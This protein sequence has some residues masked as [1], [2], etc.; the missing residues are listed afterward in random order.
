LNRKTTYIL[1]TLVAITV[2]FAIW[3]QAY[4]H[5]HK[6]P[7]NDR[8]FLS[9]YTSDTTRY[10]LND[11]Y[12][13]P[14][15]YRNRNPF[16]LEDSSFIKRNIVY[17]PLTK[18]YYIEEKIGNNYYRT[19]MSF[20]MKEFLD[21]QGKMDE[22]DYFRKR[23]SLLSSMNRRLYKP[24]FKFFNNWVNRI[25]GNGKIDIRPTGYVDL[26]AGYTGQNIK[27]PT[28]P[29][30]ARKNGGFDFNMNSQLQVDANIG[31]KLKLPINYN[32]QSVFNF[33][34]QL[35]LDYHGEDDEILKEFQAGNVSFNSKG[36]LIP[37]AQ[38]LFGLK[39]QLQFGKLFITSV[40]ANQ[41][42]QRQ[43]LGLQGSSA[44]QNFALKADEYE[45]NRHFLLAQ[46]FRNKYNDA[47]KEL[48]IVRSAVQVQKMEVWVTNRTAYTDTRDIVALMDL[49]EGSPFGPWGGS[50][51]N[52][53]P[54]NNA[55]SLYQALLAN[56][57]ARNSTQAQSALTGMGLQPVQ[58][59]EKTYA[60]KLQPTEYYYNPQIGFLSLNQQ[61]Q[62]DEVLGV[63]YQYTYNGKVYQVGEFSQDVPPDSTANNQ[64][65]L[66][67]KLLKAT[68]QRPQLPIWDLMMKNV[69]SVG[70]GQLDRKDFQLDILYEEPSLGQKRYLPPDPV[71]PQY[72]GQ[73]I[74]SLVNLDRLN[75]QNDPVP[76]GYFDYVE[77]FT[78]ISSQSRI[79]FP[80]L[81]PFGHDLDYVYA[82]Q[83][84]RDK[85]LYYP[86]YDTIKAIAQTYANLDRFQLAGRSTSSGSGDYQ[87]GFNIPRGSVTVT[88]GGQVLQENVD[89]EINYDLG[90]LK[91]INPAIISTGLPVQVQYENNATYGLQQKN[92]I[93]I[94]A[95]YLVNRHL[96]LGATMVRLGERPFFTKTSYGEDPVKNTMYGADFDYRN[97]IPRLSKWLDKLPFYSTKA[98]SSITA[99]GEVAVLDPG[100]PKQIGKG[101]QGVSYIDDFEGTRSDID[102]RFP[103]IGWTLASVPYNAVD[104]SNN[105]LFPEAALNNNL[106]SGYNRAKLAWY[107]IEPVLQEKNNTSNPIRRNLAELSK[108]ESR[109]VLQS[110]IFPQRSTELGLGVLTTFDLAYYPREKGP[111]NFEFHNGRV[112]ANG[113]L[114][115]PKQ[116]WGGIMRNIDQ[117]D[118]E[119]SNIE[120]IEFWLQ[121]PFIRKPF[122]NGGQL[123]FNLGNISEDILKD[124]KRQYENGLAT[125]KNPQLMDT[126][127][128]WGQVPKNPLQVT[129]AFS[130]DPEDR[131]LQDVGYD[132]LTDTAEIRKFS[133]YL[134]DLSALYGP[135]SAIYQKALKDPSADDFK[136]Y[137]DD[138]YGEN[139]G[140]LARY[141]D[142]NNPHG[143]SP[144][145]NN[146]SQFTNAFTLYPDQEDLNRDNTM[147]ETEEYFQYRV[148]LKPGSLVPGQNFITD[149]REA[150]VKLAD[151]SSR[152]EHWYLF[153]IPIKAYQAKVG[154]IP[155]F[156][157]IRFI[158]MF[159]TGFD[160]TVV[161]RFGK[162]ELV[163]NQWRKFTYQIDTTGN[164][165]TLP[166]NDPVTTNILAVNLEENDQREPI[167]Y[168]IPPGIERQQ[169]LS[170]N[171]VQLLLNE[172]SLSLQVCSLLKNQAR[173]VFKTLNL[174]LRQ[175]GK[176]SMFIHLEDAKNPGN[177]IADGDVNAVI[178]L[179]NDF[180]SNYYEIKIPLKVTAW[181]ET[182]SARIW[183]PENNLDFDL[184]DLVALKVLRNKTGISPSLYFKQTLSNGRSYGI[185]GNP[186]LGEVRGMLM[187]IENEA[188]ENI[189]AEAWFNELRLSKLD[190]KG[191]YAAVGRV[192]INLA[193]LG[194]IS[195]AGSMHSAGFG[196]LEQRVNERSKEDQYQFDLAT[197]LDLGKL[198]PKRAG[199]QIPVYAGINRTSATPQY[200]PYDL[201]IKLKD[202]LKDETSK[203]KRDSIR[204]DAIDLTTTKTVT[205]N[206][207]RKIRT[208]KGKPMPWDVSNLDFNYS[209]IQTLH[210]SPLIEL[211][212]LR[213]TRG[214]ITYSYS[215]QV[216]PLEPFK[217]LIRS[218]SPWLALIRDFN[219]NYAP[220]VI[221]VKADAFRQFGA[222]RPRNVG[223]GPYK[224]PET[225][226]KFFNFDRYY[227]VNWALTNSIRIDYSA[228]NNA[229]VDEPFG[230]I[231][232][233]EKKDSIR[234]NFF[235]GG[236]T[237]HFGQDVTITYLLP[238]QKLPLLDWTAIHATYKA[239]YDWDAASLLATNLGNT[240]INGQ[241]RNVTGEFNFD[242]LYRKS[243]LL[244]LIN[245]DGPIEKSTEARKLKVKVKPNDST[246]TKMKWVRNPKWQPGPGKVTRFIGRFF[247][248]LKNVGIE[249]NEDAGTTLP[250]YLDST[251][252]FGHNFRSGNPDFGFIFGYQPDTNYINKLGARGLLTHDTLFN[253]LIQ[254]RYSQRLTIRAQLSPIRD[255][256]IDLRLEKTY[257]KNYSE[258]YKDT[259]AFDNVGL[260]R[261]NP[262]AM[263][264]F[265]ITYISYQT[266]FKKF[267]PNKLS[268]T[269][270]Q[271][272]ANR[273]L[274]SKRLSAL[275]PYPGNGT[276]DPND[277]NYYLGYGRYAQDVVIP[278]FIAAY[279]NKD[280]LSVKLIK[281]TNPNL[282]SNPF[283]GLIPKPNWTI[284]Y[285]GLSKLP[286][287]D[288]IFT[289]VTIRNG[290]RSNLSM[291]SFNTALLFEDPFHT[292]YPFF[293]DPLTNNYIPYFLV[294]N[295]TI[296]EAFEPLIGVD[297]TF[298][299]ALTAQFEYKKSRTLSLSLVD[300][301]LAENR[302]TEVS[303]GINWRKRG[304][305]I[306]RK[307]GKMKLDNEVTFKLEFSLRDD[308]T[309]NSKLDQ[310]GAF[311]T[312]G[313]KVVRIDPTIDYVINSRVKLQ[314][315]FDQTKVI[316][317]IYTT[318][319]VTNTK[320][321]VKV[322]I[323]LNQ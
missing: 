154:N 76:N 298:A 118:F 274:L 279:T 230:R 139:D 24:K 20:S 69:Y 194:N 115:N 11:R 199:I 49:G 125:P 178:R 68:S 246:S 301:Q 33:D 28:L 264:S 312:A 81:E 146:N 195:F 155:D 240:L 187:G 163:R 176:M 314:F 126:T 59:F 47:M 36:T 297:M 43:S 217:T 303:L 197:N 311:G 285:N 27:N 32:T 17:D 275:N 167:P 239:R 86:L 25:T 61:L 112:N 105:I 219:F 54:N 84:D 278:A 29:E 164:Y 280:P 116:A 65:V 51:V 215:P 271:F 267:D 244:R 226:N 196:T 133:Q 100:H 310:D 313:Q 3:P 179:G 249:Y 161:C 293:K 162:L 37:G 209:Y 315:Y 16:Y 284:T 216:K 182:D 80:V 140:I 253:S 40:L 188:Q 38:S 4:A 186:N 263:G 322:T 171:N 251:E 46:Y 31:D 5:D 15:N 94:R 210:H 185:I 21:M 12:G 2:L 128:V 77:G 232:T 113:N 286:G 189:C 236:R 135:N 273:A 108:P 72:K 103:L 104:Q 257:D 8:S 138:S 58:D 123:Y 191:G 122:S 136:N 44:T 92:F 289:N 151:G 159:M 207:V 288:K 22:E 255:L 99:Y 158:R 308:A 34:N 88:A 127:T 64:K 174:D 145:A 132:G 201:D 85:Y 260:T 114:L 141:K 292:G 93:G 317:K 206:S 323:S 13:D 74:L 149:V 102:L 296:S 89:Y 62:P 316:P 35:K 160:D 259:S 90:T 309:S 45:E 224:V 42:S 110:E 228:V 214:A 227:I 172:Q 295:I 198:L 56:P 281:N 258:L 78:V 242:Q 147:N 243:K 183:W 205:F 212:E 101:G 175:Y 14:Y 83:A 166:T 190:E 120:Y 265:N 106:A 262:Y 277:P 71:V 50:G 177:T 237:T 70:Y 156:K 7:K 134:T 18:E 6:D 282:R 302:S 233:K 173:G 153:R 96:T 91:I 48:P 231:D 221:S 23:A 283:S 66:F 193:D 222:T 53:L 142:Y 148:D 261:L 321:G 287:L 276:P 256:T 57:A 73:P 254:Q 181:G 192:D 250:G 165:T 241:T 211:D 268:E 247:T 152:T 300:Y 1:R 225:Y 306:I 129:N 208:G 290:Y 131:P 202:K 169:E 248:A 157:S 223:G 60:R 67:L 270:K 213:R 150:N 10:P 234:K 75:D 170:N 107:N 87:L 299:N 291:N 220:N 203:T 39:T 180:V 55:N 305:P 143:N 235:K 111:Y 124:G 26:L 52:A 218:K 245:T 117:T 266:L 41:R 320:A 119:T 252:F 82:N 63:A 95:D 137:R 19:P 79:I 168:R 9:Y 294:P 204:N 269:F 272:E 30:R 229:R 98:M 109:Q 97:N 184:Q 238:T 318:A 121:D 307:I 130:N 200:D 144:I 304:V 319:P